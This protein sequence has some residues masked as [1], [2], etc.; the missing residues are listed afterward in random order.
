MRDIDKAI[1]EHLEAVLEE[2][3]NESQILGV[4]LYGSQNYGTNT[5]S[6]DVDTKC[7]LVPTLE[8]LC[9]RR[10]VSKEIHLENGEH[11]EVKDIREIVAN[12]R[13]QNINFLEI[14]YTP[15]FWINPVYEK[16][17]FDRF[18]NNRE[19]ISH[20]DMNRALQSICGQ[21][22][23]TLKQDKT[24][25]KKVSNGLR[26]YWFLKKYL[27]GTNYNECIYLEDDKRK[28]LKDLKKKTK[29][30]D[31]KKVDELIS[32]FE[33]FRTLI[34]NYV[35]DKTSDEVDKIMNDAILVAVRTLDEKQVWKNRSDLI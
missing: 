3:Y 29:I 28:I 12:F 15:Y 6:S 17:W 9:L 7:I 1:K 34:V 24:N 16:V 18:V 22:I 20:Y 10:P 27:V 19:F 14:L 33:A 21:A 32:N 31:T 2:G 26:L 35:G 4:F 11:C 30:K 8:D 5:F 13:K 23:H 25:R